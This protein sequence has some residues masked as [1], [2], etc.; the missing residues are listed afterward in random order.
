MPNPQ[1]PPEEQDDEA[2]ALM[3]ALAYSV[4]NE[5]S[6]NYSI[7]L[8]FEVESVRQLDEIVFHQMHQEYLITGMTTEMMQIYVLAM[9]AYIGQIL[10]WNKKCSWKLDPK[11]QAEKK[12]DQNSAYLAT[13]S[14]QQMFVCNWCYK[15]IVNGAGDNVWS[16]FQ[17]ALLLDEIQKNMVLPPAAEILGKKGEGSKSAVPPKQLIQCPYCLEPMDALP[18]KDV[19]RECPICRH[20]LFPDL[21]TTPLDQMNRK[22]RL[23][24][25]VED[26]RFVLGNENTLLRSY[27]KWVTGYDPEYNQMQT[28]LSQ[29]GAKVIEFEKESQILLSTMG[30]LEEEA[31]GIFARIAKDDTRLI[32][33]MAER[34]SFRLEALFLSLTGDG[35]NR[36]STF[37]LKMVEASGWGS[38][39]DSRERDRVLN[40]LRNRIPV[41]PVT[42]FFRWVKTKFPGKPA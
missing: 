3:K 27:K 4:Q 41:S 42:R 32:G 1:Q 33:W 17:T 5:I 7:E 34:Q 38:Y 40:Q 29:R 16:K 13:E 22:Q 18:E 9:G 31:F 15:R 37:Q 26:M 10:R 25:I 21:M 20:N 30:D 19:F 39:G 24:L 8:N 12:L 2:N 6:R 11:A 28:E 23:K 36:I 35:K 14:G